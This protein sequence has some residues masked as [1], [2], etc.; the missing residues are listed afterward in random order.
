MGRGILLG[1]LAFPL[2]IVLL[3]ALTRQ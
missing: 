3:L 1:T 2:P